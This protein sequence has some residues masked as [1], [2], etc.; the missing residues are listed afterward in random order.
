VSPT[1]IAGGVA[2]VIIAGLGIS[3]KIVGERLLSKTE[4]IGEL[5]VVIKGHEAVA[6]QRGRD[7]DLS[8]KIAD[9][10]RQVSDALRMAAMPARETIIHVPAKDGCP[11]GEPNLAAASAGVRD[12]RSA[13]AGA[14][15]GQTQTGR[16]APAAVRPADRQP[17]GTTRR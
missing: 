6:A 10:Q 17:A 3:L 12:V 9:V 2:V 4:E 5:K 7:E 13:Y 8:M 1:L 11:A 14:R 16:D 15:A